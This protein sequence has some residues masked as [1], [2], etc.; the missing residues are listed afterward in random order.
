MPLPA[1]AAAAALATLAHFAHCAPSGSRA[2]DVEPQ[3]D[4]PD[5][6]LD[7]YLDLSNIL[8][9]VQAEARSSAR[10][11]RKRLSDVASG[12]MQDMIEFQGFMVL[13][14]G[15]GRVVVDLGHGYVAK[16][17]SW[18]GGRNQNKREFKIWNS[19]KGELREMLV[20]VLRLDE[21]G[22][23]ILAPKVD[24]FDELYRAADRTRAEEMEREADQAMRKLRPLLGHVIDVDFDFNWGF[25]E[26]KLK[27]LDYGQ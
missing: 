19:S 10:L 6:V 14:R 25:H 4:I 11:A 1:L 13:G 7:K 5:E 2:G 15:G 18:Q 9:D 26:G 20:P 16:L 21:A 3:L 8:S 23:I 12:L 17:A 27:L 24:Q 22:G